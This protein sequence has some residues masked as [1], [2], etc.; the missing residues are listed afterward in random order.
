MSLL[1][2]LGI[3]ETRETKYSFDYQSYN[4]L[5]GELN[6]TFHFNTSLEYYFNFVYTLDGSE[7]K[8]TFFENVLESNLSD[9]IYVLLPDGAVVDNTLN[10]QQKEQMLLTR[11]DQLLA[12][13]GDTIPLLIIDECSLNQLSF[14]ESLFLNK[15]NNVVYLKYCGKIKFLIIGRE[16]NIHKRKFGIFNYCKLTRQDNTVTICNHSVDDFINFNANKLDL[17]CVEDSTG[18]LEHISKIFK[19]EIA[20]MNGNGAISFLLRR[21]V[22]VNTSLNFGVLFDYVGI[23]G[24]Y[25]ILCLLLKHTNVY[26]LPISSYEGAVL[27]LYDYN[28]SYVVHSNIYNKEDYLVDLLD[29]LI[30]DKHSRKYKKGSVEI[31]NLLVDDLT[32]NDYKVFGLD[33]Y[34]FRSNTLNIT[35]IQDRESFCELVGKLDKK[36]PLMCIF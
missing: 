6:S 5:T 12:L 20:S 22:I 23:G 1:T 11:I 7:G 17:L 26:L 13:S 14:L 9:N 15:Y 29:G 35:H 10:K 18:G 16:L 3:K 30:L 2:S 27:E 8:S 4:N 19:T 28:I 36:D 32:N 31:S 24:M 33:R 21:G 34:C 25:N